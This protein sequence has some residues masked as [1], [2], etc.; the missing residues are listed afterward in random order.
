MLFPLLI[1]TLGYVLIPVAFF[2]MLKNYQRQNWIWAVL[3]AASIFIGIG[4][5]I[6]LAYIA[7]LCYSQYKSHSNK[8]V[9][10]VIYNRDGSYTVYKADSARSVSPATAVFRIIGG[11]VAGIFIVYGL[12]FVGLT[13]FISISCSGNSKCM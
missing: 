12:L 7:T 10:Q 6:A 9:D 8:Q 4:P 13:I 1:A 11:V 5:F 3:L 2:F